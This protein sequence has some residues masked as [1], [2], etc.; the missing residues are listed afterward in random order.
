[1]E[2]RIEKVEFSSDLL[3][4]LSPRYP[5]RIASG[6]Y[7]NYELRFI[8]DIVGEISSVC[9]FYTNMGMLEYPVFVISFYS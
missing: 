5:T 2:L 4:S 8:P 9:T 1:M 7:G 6:S 3:M